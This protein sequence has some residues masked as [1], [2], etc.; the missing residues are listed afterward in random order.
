LIYQFVSFAGCPDYR[1]DAFGGQFKRRN[2]VSWACALCFGSHLGEHHPG[3][4]WECLLA[5]LLFAALHIKIEPH[6]L[7]Y[8]RLLGFSLV[9]G[10]MGNGVLVGITPYSNKIK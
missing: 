8:Q 10:I 3:V 4:G 2:P 6:I 1:F 7:A 5:S 9:L